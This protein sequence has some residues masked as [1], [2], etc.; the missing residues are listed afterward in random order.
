MYISLK[1]KKISERSYSDSSANFR[2]F[3]VITQ[4]ID[5]MNCGTTYSRLVQLKPFNLAP[6]LLFQL[7]TKVYFGRVGNKG[8]KHQILHYRERSQFSE[9]VSRA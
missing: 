8:P 4:T 7:K 6:V 3:C 1:L 2:Y 5:F 9:T